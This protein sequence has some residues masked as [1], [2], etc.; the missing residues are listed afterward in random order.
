[1]PWALETV[2]VM[3]MQEADFKFKLPWS[4]RLE[5]S[6]R[7]SRIAWFHCTMRPVFI[8]SLVDVCKILVRIFQANRSSKASCLP[9]ANLRVSS[10]YRPFESSKPTFKSPIMP[11]QSTKCLFCRRWYINAAAYETHLR[12]AHT[13]FFNLGLGRSLPAGTLEDSQVSPEYSDELLHSN[14]L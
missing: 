14:L 2:M 7:S 8:Y 5:V 1:M 11:T 6:Q 13:E 3:T 9:P 4:W 10:R 12:T